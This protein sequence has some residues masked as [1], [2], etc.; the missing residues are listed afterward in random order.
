MRK[1]ALMILG[2]NMFHGGKRVRSKSP[3]LQCPRHIEEDSV[4]VVKGDRR[5]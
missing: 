4:Y 2:G 5:K 3:N 1:H